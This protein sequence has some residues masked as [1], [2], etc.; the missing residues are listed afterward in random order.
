MTSLASQLNQLRTTQRDEISL[1]SRT[2]VSFLFDIKQAANIDDQTLFFMCQSAL[3]QLPTD[4]APFTADILHDKSL[5]FYRGTLT[6]DALKPIDEKIEALIKQLAAH[7]MDAN[8][9]KVIEYLLRIYEVHIYHKES[10][11]AAFL[12]YF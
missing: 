3:K 10:L 12:P 4:L 2:R 5:E 7:L 6:R 9:H 8:A 1:P 11:L